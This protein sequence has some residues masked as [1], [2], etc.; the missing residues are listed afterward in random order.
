MNAPHSDAGNTK[1]T[2]K[3]HSSITKKQTIIDD[4]IFLPYLCLPKNI[5]WT[6]IECCCKRARNDGEILLRSNKTCMWCGQTVEKVFRQIPSDLC[7]D[8]GTV[9]VEC[10][11]AYLFYRVCRRLAKKMQNNYLE[12]DTDDTATNYGL[13]VW[14]NNLSRRLCRL[15]NNYFAY[16]TGTIKRRFFSEPPTYTVK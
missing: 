6:T 16:S 13:K 3:Q 5:G 10:I 4:C 8:H 15:P 7:K 9:R 11:V 14:D 2:L 1:N 12:N